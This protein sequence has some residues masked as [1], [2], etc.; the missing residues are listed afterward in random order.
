MGLCEVFGAV[1]ADSKVNRHE[2]AGRQNPAFFMELMLTKQQ[3]YD[4]IC[5]EAKSPFVNF[6]GGCIMLQ[7]NAELSRIDKKHSWLEFSL[8]RRRILI[9]HYNA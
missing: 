5:S 3:I 7:V 1:S 4:I 2:K 8:L 6:A 9:I